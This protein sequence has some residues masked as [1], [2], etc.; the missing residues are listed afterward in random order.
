MEKLERLKAA[1]SHKEGDR[2]PVADFFWT[3]FMKKAK[4]KW[5]E[6][7]DPYRYF[8][9]DYIVVNPNMD[10]H[11]KDF[12]VLE[13]K[14]EDITIRTG[15]EAVARRSGDKAMPHFES[16]SIN[17]PEEMESF[18]F[19]APDDKRRLYRDGDDQINGLGDALNRNTPSWNKRVDM[20]KDDFPVFGSVCEPYEY[21][22]RV[23][24]T[25]N[26]LYWML[27]EEEKF[28]AFID[29]IGDFV[30]KL[31]LYQIKESKGRLSGMYIWG[32]VA[33][34]NGMLF[35]PEI[36]REMFKPHVKKI[37]KACHDAGLLVI[38]HGCGNATPIYEDF[39]EIGLDG[40]NP[41]EVKSNLDVVKLK[42]EY[43]GRLAFVGNFDVRIL[44]KGNRDEIKKEL[45][46]K[47]KAAKNG[48]WICQSDHS[49]SSD[50]EPESYAYLVE[51]VK[52]YGNFPIDY[53]K[54]EKELERLG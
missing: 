20:Y 37:I 40:Y 50:V 4:A 23:I 9:L 43:N 22:W 47:L 48:G 53:K 46:Y 1:L 3:G 18:M 38:Y 28:K 35:S 42:D 49:V 45:L 27:L 12:E 16:F 2:L 15:F 34:V 25:E 6:N 32:D 33:Y 13:E 8:D 14:G 54:I 51:L 21:V 29:R 10:P 41:L 7:F 52:E 11:I 17:E 44:E 30:Y 36:W 19:D 5:G 31:A 39:I 24:G 26:A